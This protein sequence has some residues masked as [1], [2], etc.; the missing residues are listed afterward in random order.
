MR[1]S[2]VPFCGLE[3]LVQ[4][5]WLDLLIFLGHT[6]ASRYIYIYDI[7]RYIYIYDISICMYIYIYLMYLYVCIYI[8]IYNILYPAKKLKIICSW[9]SPS[10][11]GDGVCETVAQLLV[12]SS[13]VDQ[14]SRSCLPYLAPWPRCFKGTIGDHR[15]WRGSSRFLVDIRWR[16]MSYSKIL[17]QHLVVFRMLFPKDGIATGNIAIEHG[18]L[19]ISCKSAN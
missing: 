1:G 9:F 2:R 14:C 19:S 16:I 4:L 15:G 12:Q 8:C 3:E 11:F 10:S 6:W 7:S 5:Q 18:N 13:E 17:I